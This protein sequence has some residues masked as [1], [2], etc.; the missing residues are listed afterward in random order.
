MNNDLVM[1]VNFY[2]MDS[3]PY[4]E[5]MQAICKFSVMENGLIHAIRCENT[6]TANRKSE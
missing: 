3:M 1:I 2:F 5:F 6:Y 4:L